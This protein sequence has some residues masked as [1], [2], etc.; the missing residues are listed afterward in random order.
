MILP[1]A[2]ETS[3]RTPRRRHAEALNASPLEHMAVAHDPV[4]GEQ[5]FGFP[6]PDLLVAML[7]GAVVFGRVDVGD[8]RLARDGTGL[9]RGAEGEPVVGIDHVMRLACG[10]LS[11]DGGE[12]VD[13]LY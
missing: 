9:H 13:F 6:L 10:N 4:G 11:G 3:G 12:P 7:A 8:E 2:T 5:P 1:A